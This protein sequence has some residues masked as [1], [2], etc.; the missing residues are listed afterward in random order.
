MADRR[1]SPPPRSRRS[2][3]PAPRSGSSGTARRPRCRSLHLASTRPA[4]ARPRG[5]AAPGRLAAPC[6]ASGPA[7]EDRAPPAGVLADLLDRES[8]HR[9][10]RA[11]L[12]SSVLARGISMLELGPGQ[13]AQGERPL[14]RLQ[15]VGGDHRVERQPL[16]LDAVAG[17]DDLV[18]L[19]VVRPLLDRS[20]SPR[21]G[22]KPISDA[23]QSSCWIGR[24][25][26]ARP[27]RTRPR[28]PAARPM[29]T[30]S[31]RIGG[32]RRR[33]HVEG[34]ASAAA[35]APRALVERIEVGRC[36]RPPG[37]ASG[38]GRPRRLPTS[39]RRPREQAQAGPLAPAPRVPWP[40]ERAMSSSIRRNPRARGTRPTTAG[41][42]SRRAVPRQVELD[43]GHVADDGGQILRHHDLIVQRLDL[44]A[45]LRRGG[46]VQ[47]LE[48]VLD[49]AEL[50]EQLRGA[51]CRRCRGRR[52]CCPRCRPAAP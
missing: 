26:V 35:S 29:P 13:V 7:A 32:P 19:G 49:A 46:L 10:R 31:A 21:I 43:A 50:V 22:A 9:G 6:R 14:V 3:P 36:R 1:V 16:G 34:D 41:G 37:P 42:R 51:S 47:V 39:R 28:R 8:V 5:T 25:R 24:R 40:I 44:G 38:G 2:A 20:A 15:Q 17:Q 45:L 12:P 23:G 52:G 48:Q 18:E 11:P 4:A 27:G 30:I 33:L